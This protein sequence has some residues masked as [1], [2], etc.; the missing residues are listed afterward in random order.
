MRTICYK[1][2]NGINLLGDFY[3]ASNTN[4]PVIVYIHGGGF[5]FGSRKEILQEQV[6]QYNQAG[7]HV[8]SIDYRLAPETKLPAIIEDVRDALRW[9]CD[10]APSMLD[11]EPSA[12]AVIGSSAG[13]YLALLAGSK[14]S[15]V[16]A[17]VSFYGYG[18]IRGE[19]ASEPS[20][21]YLQKTIV[22][23]KLAD[24]LITK[25]ILTE[26]SI[27]QRFGLYLYYRQQG[28]WI[29][30]TTGL[31]PIQ[32]KEE[33]R[34][35]CP[36]E[37]VDHSSPPIML[38]HGETDHDVPCEESICMAERLK[39]AGIEHTLLTLPGEDHLFDRQLDKENV[40]QAFAQVLD[41]LHRHLT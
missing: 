15:Y 2:V 11:I 3:S 20:P 26:N 34:L 9:V 30:E 12:I 14:E 37:C 41:F 16:K 21:F 32:N 24:Q 6:K 36:I 40:Q 5:I 28:S 39:R 29:R 10:Q 38:L 23:K 1:T 4:S 33:L 31:D 19:W 22:P 13:G 35:L 8:F 27:Q 17:V 25:E 7:F 18:D